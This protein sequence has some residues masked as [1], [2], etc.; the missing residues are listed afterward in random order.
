M[1]RVGDKVICIEPSVTGYDDL[2]GN[3]IYEIIQINDTIS[4]NSD[5]LEP[6]TCRVKSIDNIAVERYLWNLSRFK[7]LREEKLKKILCLK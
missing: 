7:N 2:I 4:L 3:G 6:L 5:N 1:F